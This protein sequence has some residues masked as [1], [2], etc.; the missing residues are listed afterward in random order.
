MCVSMFIIEIGWYIGLI[1]W[2]VPHHFGVSLRCYGIRLF[3]LRGVGFNGFYFLAHF[4][5]PPL[6]IY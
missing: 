1:V 2:L 5:P 4:L 6:N 3:S